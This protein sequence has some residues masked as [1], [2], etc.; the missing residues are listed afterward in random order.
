MRKLNES[1]AVVEL[2]ET[3]AVDKPAPQTSGGA[4]M[5][6]KPNNQTAKPERMVRVL[7]QRA[8]S[9]EAVPCK[10][11]ESGASAPV[12]AGL[13]QWIDRG[14]AIRLSADWPPQAA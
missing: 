4:A 1:T 2:P 14:S 7:E 10:V 11:A 8:R 3:A 9:Q 6:I 12:L 5:P 13:A